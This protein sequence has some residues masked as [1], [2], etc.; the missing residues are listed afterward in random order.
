MSTHG[1]QPTPRQLLA[2]AYDR[3]GSGLFRYA[4]LITAHHALA[5]D[6]VQQAF[7]K[8]AGMGGRIAELAAEEHYLRRAVRNEC[9]RLLM[10]PRL[11]SS[12]SEQAALLEPVAPNAGVDAALE[13]QDQCQVIESAVRELPAEQREIV[14]LKVYEDLTFQQI[15]DLLAIPLNTAASRYRYATEKLRQALAGLQR[16]QNGG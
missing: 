9:Y 15:A 8:L 7:A 6:A 11:V 12:D 2:D 10:V 5:E 13:S 14:H 3:H 1:N 16:A 4:L